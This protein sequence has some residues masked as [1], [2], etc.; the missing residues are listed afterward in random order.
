MEVQE[1]NISKINEKTE[2]NN[3]FVCLFPSFLLLHIHYFKG[4]VERMIYFEKQK[5]FKR[6]NSTF[7]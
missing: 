5:L 6:K 2:N 4:L 7:I 1:H 3:I